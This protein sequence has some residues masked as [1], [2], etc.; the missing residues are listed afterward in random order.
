MKRGVMF[1][2]LFLVSLLVLSGCEQGS[3]SG[4]A[5]K[6]GKDDGKDGGKEESK[7]DSD[8]KKK[9]S[10]GLPVSS[11]SEQ[12][13]SVRCEDYVYSDC[14]SS[15]TKICIPSEI[16]LPFEGFPLNCQD[17]EGSCVSP[18]GEDVEVQPNGHNQ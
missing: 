18:V 14:P 15:C 11:P 2:S 13:P 3:F 9:S 17:V 4:Y 1:L 8:G 7:G 10:P 6:D 5:T 12:V 16:R